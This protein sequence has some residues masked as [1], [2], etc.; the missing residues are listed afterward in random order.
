MKKIKNILLPSFL[1]IIVLCVLTNCETEEKKRC[2]LVYV[3]LTGSMDQYGVDHVADKARVIWQSL[4][5]ESRMVVK[6][7]DD[8]DARPAIFDHRLPS[9]ASGF[10]KDIEALDYVLDSL[11]QVLHDTLH[12]LYQEH[13]QRTK[14]KEEFSSCIINSFPAISRFFNDQDTCDNRFELV[15][16]SDMVEECSAK[17]NH[18]HQDIKMY[19]HSGGSKPDTAVLAS[20][21][22]EGFLPKLQ[23]KQFVSPD[24]VYCVV[25]PNSTYIG[26]ASCLQTPEIEDLWGVI[27]QKLGYSKEDLHRIHF[28]TEL[29]PEFIN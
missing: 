25:T 27:F 28:S 4:D 1:L 23:L 17:Y 12:L 20:R 9:I 26:N 13:S 29:P 2:V 10:D 5:A 22:R 18:V 24:H 15:F 21:L 8:N 11:G 3:D 14:G 16:L 7:I 19:N 6:L